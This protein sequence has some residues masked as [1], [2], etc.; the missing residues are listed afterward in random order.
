M[1]YLLNAMSYRSIDDLQ[2]MAIDCFNSCDYI[3]CYIFYL[4]LTTLV[5]D[6]R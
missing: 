6:N 5:T 3:A 2:V 1:T 4:L